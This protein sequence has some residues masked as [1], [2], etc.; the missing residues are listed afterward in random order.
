MASSKF[1]NTK[2]TVVI[3]G[4]TGDVG[5]HISL[6][7]LT[8]FRSAFPTIRITTRN[9]KSPKAREL[10]KLGADMRRLSEPPEDV[11]S[12]AEVVVDAL[13]P[14]VAGDYRERIPGALLREKV[15]VYFLS[16]YGM[17]YHTTDFKGYDHDEWIMKR[18]I[19]AATSAAVQGKTKIVELVSG[20]FHGWVFRPD[21]GIDVA[22][23]V[24]TP[25]GPGTLRFATT[26][27]SD[28]GRSIARLA[29]LSLDPATTAAVPSRLR[30]TGHNV[31][32]DEIRDIVA[33]VKGVP[34]GTIKSGD[35]RAAK[36]N[37]RKHPSDNIMD[38]INVLVGE[39][40]GDYADNNSNELVN[41]G[42]RFWMW[43]S[44]E[45]ELRGTPQ[46]ALL[47]YKL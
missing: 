4:G 5:M 31:S 39:G 38:Y 18:Q 1:G 20:M 23:N 8:E 42:Q 40:K 13:P 10:A 28:I 21:L 44:I 11:F 41:P 30:I 29:I 33:R 25:L 14:Q 35:V 12:G 27:E 32:Y 17:D 22:K 45:E 19:A 9:P 37:L 7:F 2:A 36:D 46:Q 3:L 24:Y 47:R 15:K 43:R 16:E 34:K 6:V 26:G